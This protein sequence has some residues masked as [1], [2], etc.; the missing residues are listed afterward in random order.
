MMNFTI[1]YYI[2][3]NKL[4]KP[5]MLENLRAR[6]EG[7]SEDEVVGGITDSRDLSL[8]KLQ[9]MVNDKEAWSCR[10]PWHSRVLSSYT[11]TMPI[12]FQISRY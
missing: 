12:R 9:Q 4:E 11:I 3:I 1:E 8:N 5:L 6:G 7:V 10:S 2:T